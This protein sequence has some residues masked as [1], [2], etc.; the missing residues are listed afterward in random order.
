M[1]LTTAQKVQL[2]LT[3]RTASGAVAKI[4]G[5]PEWNVDNPAVIALSVASDGL[6]ATASSTGTVGAAQVTAKVD[7]DLG[8][9][10]TEITGLIDFNVVEVEDRATTVEIT[11]GT[12]EPR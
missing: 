3:P 12:P 8:A 2:T 6:S 4:D 10:V 9:G 1:I 5:V 11:A 7:A